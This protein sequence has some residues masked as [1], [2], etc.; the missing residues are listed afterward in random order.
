MEELY[1]KYKEIIDSVLDP[2]GRRTAKLCVSPYI[3]D[4]AFWNEQKQ[5]ASSYANLLEFVFQNFP[6]N[7]KIQEALEYPP[8]LENFLNSLQIY[9]KNMA[10]ARVDVFTTKDGLKMVESNTEI[11]GGNE[12]SYFLEQEWMKLF[13]P[14]DVNT[15]PR[16]EIVYNTL[17]KHYKIQAEAQGMPVKDKINIVLTQWQKEIDRILGEYN[18]LIDFIKERGHSCSVIDPHKVTIR[19]NKAFDPDGNEID[20]IYRRFTSDELP[21]F[22]KDSWNMAIAWDKAK[23][24]VVNPF[25][26]KRVDSKNIMVLFRDPEYTEVF[27]SELKQDLDNVRKI[28]PWTRKIKEKILLKDDTEVEAKPYLLKEKDNIVIKHANAYSSAAVYIGVDIDKEKWSDIVAEAMK[29]DWLVQE[30]ID[31]PW[32]DIDY[33]EDNQVKKAQCIFNV[34]PYIYDG[35]IGGFLNRASTDKLTSFKSGEIATVMPCFEKK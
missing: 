12:E 27:P 33:W 30:M 9:P 2:H 23:V 21:K 28:I 11:P 20:L 32:I 26:T 10:A 18:I 24:A 16:M 19:D 15:V 17:M 8:A 22:A 29:G 14:E 1:R 3:Y 6:T 13:N 5:I 31:L 35:E 4:K 34:N 25:C 7:K